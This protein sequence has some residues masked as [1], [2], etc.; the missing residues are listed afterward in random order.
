M[1]TLKR[2]RKTQLQ[3]RT[4]LMGLWEDHGLTFPNQLGKTMNAR[5]LTA[6][7]VKPLLKRG[8][9]PH[10]VRLH[11]LRHTCATI[12]FKLDNI[13]RRYRN[14]WDMPTSPSPWTPTLTYYPVWAMA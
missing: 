3:E 2:H 10:S 13:L 11:D 1:N 9:L 5:N 7:S 14:Y 8:G 6:R 12:L 4:R